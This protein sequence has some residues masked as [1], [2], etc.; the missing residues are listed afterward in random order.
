MRVVLL[1]AIAT[2]LSA[3]SGD[4]AYNSLTAAFEAQRA[5]DLD[6]AVAAFR[7]AAAASPERA[8]IR[9]NYAYA[10]LKTGDTAL[11]REQFREAMRLDPA[12]SHVALEYA[13]LIFEATENAPANKAEARR[14]FAKVAETGDETAKAAFRNIDDALA[15]QIDRWQKALASSPP[16]FSARYEL[17]QLAEQRDL[18]ELAVANYRA[19]FAI[20]PGRKGVLLELARAERARGNERGAIAALLAARYGGESRSAEMARAAL[21]ERYPYVYEFRDALELDPA[22]TGLHREL[23]YLLLGMAEKE[24]ERRAEAIAEFQA[25]PNDAAAAEQLRLLTQP[26]SR[27]RSDV[28]GLAEKSYQAGYLQDAKRY[29]EQALEDSPY[30]RSIDLKLGWTNNMLHDDAEAMR[31]FERASHSPDAAI[32]LEA[33]QA[34]SNLRQSTELVRSTVWLYP[35]YSSRWSDLFGYGQLKTELRH[36]KLKVHPYLSVR[37]VGDARRSTGGVSPQNLSESAFIAG[38]GVA[39]DYWHRGMAWFEAGEMIGY[40]NGKASPDYRGGI[41]YARTFGASLN[42]ESPGSFFETTADGV[43]VS[44]Y[45]NDLLL[46]SQN[47]VGYTGFAGAWRLQPYFGANLTADR[48]G[49]YWANFIETGLGFRWRE[50]SMPASMWVN[51]SVM[52]GVYLINSGNPGAPNFK[53]FR[54]GI[55]YA[56]TR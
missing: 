30:D 34:Y 54:L 15:T 22:S 23:G 25:I 40:L 13:F 29:F 8:D 49:Q 20:E 10:L 24:P 52:R 26:A 56:F 50:R 41:S 42:A 4:P 32:A 39:T 36:S 35:L 43:F 48:S 12:D 17:A 33:R 19:A 9:K 27:K 53:D 31:W 3:Q 18:N 46:N 21:P 2:A 7:E 47:R 5:G 44:H 38:A 51:A 14:I 1:F 55:W 6:K 11:A 45:G 16:T 28:R 37:L